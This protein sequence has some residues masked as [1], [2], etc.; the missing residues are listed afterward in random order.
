MLIEIVVAD[1]PCEGIEGITLSS[2][3]LAV[4]VMMGP[5][6]NQEQ[7][8]LGTGLKLATTGFLKGGKAIFNQND[9][10]KTCLK[11]T[12][13]DL[14]LTWADARRNKYHALISLGKK[15][16]ALCFNLLL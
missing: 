10:R 8:P 2:S 5:W 3:N 1:V 9:D 13:H 4:I 14:F 11:S 16:A 15:T 7:T 12:P 6:S